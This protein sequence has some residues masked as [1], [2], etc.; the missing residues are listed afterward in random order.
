MNLTLTITGIPPDCQIGKLIKE[1]EA[2]CSKEGLAMKCESSQFVRQIEL[3]PKYVRRN[4]VP[5]R[6]DSST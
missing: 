2:I 5:I 6:R 4:V 3:V 1:L